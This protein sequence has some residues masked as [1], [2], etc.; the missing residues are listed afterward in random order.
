MLRNFYTGIMSFAFRVNT[1]AN[2]PRWKYVFKRIFCCTHQLSP[3]QTT[4]EIAAYSCLI[5]KKASR[6]IYCLW[7]YGK[8]ND[9]FACRKDSESHYSFISS[10]SRHTFRSHLQ[11]ADHWDENIS[12]LDVKGIP[13]F[14]HFKNI[15]RTKTR[16]SHI[17]KGCIGAFVCALQ[18]KTHRKA[19][20]RRKDLNQKMCLYV[21]SEIL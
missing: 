10:F 17:N 21:I 13:R 19:R 7:G 9:K 2:N 14:F 20:I 5:K 16:S 8:L 18:I 4:D 3:I 11:P 15:S 6:I 12:A 1:S